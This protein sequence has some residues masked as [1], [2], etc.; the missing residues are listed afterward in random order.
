MSSDLIMKIAISSSIFLAAVCVGIIT[1]RIFRTR[2]GKIMEEAEQDLDI[3]YSEIQAQ[4]VLNYTIYSIILMTI[5]GFILTFNIIITLIFGVVG[6]FIP[7]LYL[8]RQRKKRMAKFDEQ[9][10]S[11]ID[12]MANSLKSGFSLPQSFEMITQEMDPPISQE[13]GL[14]VKENRL[15]VSLGEAL[16]NMLERVKSDELELVITATNIARETGGNL[17]EIYS[18]IAKTIRDRDEMKGKIDSLTAEGRMQGIFV[19]ALPFFLGILLTIIDPEMMYPMWHTTLGFA[20]VGFAV[21]LVALGGFFIK[22]LT[23]IDI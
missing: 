19:G 21:L 17:A 8:R 16:K 2:A 12:L 14:V 5:L 4:Q 6:Y 13:F 15:G 10:I 9:L 11:A 23:T 20:F 3:L 1:T 22:K 7:R 18:R